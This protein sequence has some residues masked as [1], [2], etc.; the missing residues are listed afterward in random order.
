MPIEIRSEDDLIEAFET[1]GAKDLLLMDNINLTEKW[2]EKWIDKIEHDNKYIPWHYPVLFENNGDFVIDTTAANIPLFFAVGAGSV[3]DGITINCDINVSEDNIGAFLGRQQ[4]AVTFRNCTVTGTITNTLS[5]T[6]GFT[7]AIDDS[8]FENCVN[9]ADIVCDGVHVGGISSSAKNCQFKDCENYGNIKSFYLNCGG[10]CGLAEQ[11]CIERCNNFETIGGFTGAGGIV[12]E[13]FKSLIRSCTND[14]LIEPLHV[15]IYEDGNSIVSFDGYTGREIGGIAGRSTMSIIANCLSGGQVGNDGTV[16]DFVD[17][18]STSFVGGILGADYGASVVF[19]NRN[20]A[21]V[22][23]GKFAGGIV[24]GADAGFYA[25]DITALRDNPFLI[26]DNIN[27]SDITGMSYVG[28]VLGAPLDGIGSITRNCVCDGVNIKGDLYVSGIVGTVLLGANEI[29]EISNSNNTSAAATIT[30]TS[31]VYRITSAPS[32]SQGGII[33]ELSENRAK[34]DML[35]TGTNETAD[36]S[37]T[38]SNEIVNTDDPF[39]GADNCHGA[40]AAACPEGTTRGNCLRCVKELSYECG[41]NESRQ[42]SRAPKS[43]AKKIMSKKIMPKKI[44]PKKNMSKKITKAANAAREAAADSG[45][46]RT[47]SWTQPYEN[48]FVSMFTFFCEEQQTEPPIVPDPM[49]STELKVHSST[50]IIPIAGVSFLLQGM[51]ISQEVVSGEAGEIPLCNLVPGTYTLTAADMPANWQTIEPCTIIVSSDGEIT[52]GDQ[53]ASAEV[54]V[55]HFRQYTTTLGQLLPCFKSNLR[56]AARSKGA[57]GTH[58]NIESVRTS[59]L[60]SAGK[61][62]RTIKD[63]IKAAGKEANPTLIVEQLLAN[64]GERAAAAKKKDRQPTETRF[65]VKIKADS[66][67]AKKTRTHTCM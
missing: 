35:I 18:T 4:D 20:E 59:T 51:G 14:A 16:S 67:K 15:I 27:S 66:A 57:K 22:A 8:V 21:A 28:G 43:A 31:E 63:A 37:V 65:R 5:Q 45:L 54:D 36:G 1:L 42:T 11:S 49:F 12:G 44:T 50:S 47:A 40:N 7:G 32:F 39:Y 55:T 38:Y 10:I 53:L 64:R 48:K 61:S 24:G 34:S 52:I 23:G 25:D 13:A 6:G 2:S 17:I 3:F 26:S 9:S 30:G 33:S 56:R 41:E 58:G 46:S 60:E 62:P 29:T 19:A